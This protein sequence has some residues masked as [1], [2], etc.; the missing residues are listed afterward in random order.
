M[1]LRILFVDDEPNVLDGLRRTLRGF[2]HEWDMRFAPGGAAALAALDAAPADVVVSDMRMP[3]MDGDELLAEVRRRQP[4]TVRIVLTGQCTREAML[5]VSALAHRI[6]TKPCDPDDLKAAVR[7][8]SALQGLLLNPQLTAAVG[9][10]RS[11]PSKPDLYCRILSTLDDPDASLAELG[12][13]CSQDVG[14]SA[15]LIQVAASALF[16]CKQPV[17]STLEAIRRLGT[18]TTKALVLADGI[19]TKFDPQ[20]IHPFSIDDIWSHSQSVG[21]LAAQI[22]Q[23][24]GLGA[25][26]QTLVQSVGILHDIGRLIFAS[27]DPASYVAV[28]NHAQSEGVS[29][30][31]AERHLFGVTHAEIGAYL[32][33]L[34]GLPTAVVEAIAWHH[35]PTPSGCPSDQFNLVTAVH[36]AEAILASDEGGGPD[37]EYLGRLGL[38][39]RLPSWIELAGELAAVGGA[40]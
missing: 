3:G 13:L 29:V 1:T 34:W 17:S 37:V 10:L 4:Q 28:L 22:A 6:L 2:R 33:G 14:V 36:V 31:E 23:N 35:T 24:Q 8:A 26:E 40:T 18:E 12:K 25:N 21:I 15:K 19:L 16:G 32:L 5:R 30:I 38:V 39:D 7:Q 27:T 9:R 20:S 11:V